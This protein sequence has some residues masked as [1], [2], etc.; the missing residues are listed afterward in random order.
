MANLI[1]LITYAYHSEIQN[2][3]KIILTAMA[4]NSTLKFMVYA[5]Y[6]L[7]GVDEVTYF[8]LSE[9]IEEIDKMLH[10]WKNQIEKQNHQTK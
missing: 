4:K 9:K 10:G 3:T 8:E 6:E 7:K 1:E 5:L 2:R